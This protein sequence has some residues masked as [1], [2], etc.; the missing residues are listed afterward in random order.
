ML[1]R[2]ALTCREGEQVS[3]AVG[4]CPQMVVDDDSS[5]NGKST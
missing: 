4:G 1:E 5:L 3:V 2:P